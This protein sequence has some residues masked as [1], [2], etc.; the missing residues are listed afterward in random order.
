MRNNSNNT[1][2]LKLESA[3]VRVWRKMMTINKPKDLA[4]FWKLYQCLFGQR[5]AN[6]FENIHQIVP[7]KLIIDAWLVEGSMFNFVWK[8]EL[9]LEHQT[10]KLVPSLGWVSR[11]SYWLEEIK[12]KAVWLFTDWPTAET[13]HVLRN[14]SLVFNI[15]A[16]KQFLGWESIHSKG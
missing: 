9:G 1:V 13:T 2:S 16:L 12:T 5:P 14:V 10:F 8:L 15:P 7:R 4:C 3:R 11:Y 6:R